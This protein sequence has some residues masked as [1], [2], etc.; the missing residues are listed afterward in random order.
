MLWPA[1]H[2]RKSVC[3]DTTS[4]WN[5]QTFGGDFAK[6]ATG[7]RRVCGSFW[8]S[9]MKIVVDFSAYKQGVVCKT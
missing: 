3:K 6:T 5:C 4:F 1:T 2:I 9:L 8:C 7:P